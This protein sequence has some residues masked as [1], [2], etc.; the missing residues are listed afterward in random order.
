MELKPGYKQTEVGVIPE[1]WE[2]KSLGQ[3]MEYIKGFPFKADDYQ[4][5]GIRVLRVSDTTY[6][7]IREG[8]GIY[9]DEK[10]AK[11][12][13]KW[14]LKEGDLI[15]STVGSKPPMYSSM[16]GKVTFIQARD[17]GS[18]LNQNAVIL[19]GRSSS[20]AIQR[21]LHNHFRQGRYLKYIEKIFRGNANQASITLREL[22]EY[23][24]PFTPFGAEQEA[25][26]EALSDADALIESL[27]QLI[28]K[29]RQIKQGAMQELLTGKKRLPGFSGEWEVVKA[30]DIGCFRGGSGF[31]SKFQGVTDAEFPFF[32]VSDMNNIDNKIFME[33][34]NN[35]I[36]ETQRKHLGATAFPIN[37]IVIAKVGAAIFLER[38]RILDKPS[39]LDNNMAAFT[40]DL[41]RANCRFIHYLF[42]NMRFGD[43]VSTTALP[44]LSGNVLSAIELVL[45]SCDEQT[46]ITEILSDM[47]SEIDAMEVK[48][49]KVLRIKKGMMYS[50]LT[51]KIRFI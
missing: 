42:L 25:I 47:D 19:R 1:D 46:A 20:I 9:I 3:I 50:L 29:K 12:C 11:S 38:K 5:N 23:R 45:P 6:D 21:V 48:L 2:V 36:S 35:Y 44:S 43:F 28:A 16:V 8:G 26:A 17:S 7:G 24:I 37:S 41:A 32:K 4:S 13:L 27:E 15:V 10:K 18:L 51:G 22:L 49:V 34:A 40:F 33:T 31:P 39:C 14:S 30:E